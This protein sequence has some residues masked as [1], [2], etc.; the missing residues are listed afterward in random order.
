MKKI[1]IY[2]DEG[3]NPFSVSSLLSSLKQEK[4]DHTYSIEWADKDLFQTSSWQKET[5]LVIFPGGRDIPYHEALKGTGNKHIKDFVLEGG[6]Y[7]G[8]CAGGYYGSASIEFEKGEPLEVCAPRELKFFPGIARGSAYGTGKFR[9]GSEQGAQIAKLHL[10]PSSN[11]A[12][13]FI[14]GCTFVDAEKYEDVSIIARYADIE[15]Q[16][17]AIVKCRVGAGSA[18]LCGVHPEYSAGF[19]FSKKHIGPLFNALEEIENERR[20][21]F[22]TILDQ[23]SLL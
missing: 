20:A 18:L 6:K 3:A 7:L 15:N 1:L 10:F 16:P 19:K 14:G 8:I 5:D 12:A 11:M 21:V 2:R 13:Y 4:L 9:Y 23:L 17:A 22:L